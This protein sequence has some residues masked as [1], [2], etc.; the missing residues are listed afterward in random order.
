MISNIYAQCDDYALN[1]CNNDNSCEWVEDIETGNCGNLS[2]DDC[3][4]NPECNWNCDFVDDYMGWCNYSCDGGPYEIDNSYC[5][6][7][8]NP[9]TCSEM[10]QIQCNNNGDCQWTEDI[11]IGNCSDITNSSE[12]YQTNQCSWYNAGNYGYWYDNCYGGTYEID[13]SY[14]EEYDFIQG[15]LNGDLT[16]NILDVLL[17]IDIILNQ[18]SS[19]LADING[20]GIVNILDVIELVDTIVNG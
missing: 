15:D 12:C 8:P 17:I 3:E 16:L 4:L 2:G 10:S 9:P 19:D 18:E 5:Q 11:V 14:C 20:D 13:N 6:E 1:Q 7:N